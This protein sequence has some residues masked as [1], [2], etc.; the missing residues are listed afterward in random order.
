MEKTSSNSYILPAN[1]WVKIDILPA[2]NWVKI[3]ILPADKY[4]QT[5]RRIV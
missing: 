5:V 4:M 3:D 1:N 2:N